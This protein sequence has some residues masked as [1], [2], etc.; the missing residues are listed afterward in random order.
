[1]IDINNRHSGPYM[2]SVGKLKPIYYF[3]GGFLQANFLTSTLGEWI[4]IHTDS[5]R[6][7]H[8]LPLPFYNVSACPVA[9]GIWSLF[10]CMSSP[11]FP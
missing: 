3:L 10:P 11:V 7:F 8:S 4:K 9:C 2:Y 5:R 6:M 1:M